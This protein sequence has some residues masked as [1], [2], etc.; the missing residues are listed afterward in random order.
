MQKALARK[1][2]WTALLHGVWHLVVVEAARP[3]AA[4]SIPLGATRM[5]S[6]HISDII[7]MLAA[8]AALC[9][10]AL[11]VVAQASAIRV[12]NDYETVNITTGTQLRTTFRIYGDDINRSALPAT[13]FATGINQSVIINGYMQHYTDTF[14]IINDTKKDVRTTFIFNDAGEY[15]ITWGVNLSKGAFGNIT[16][17]NE[18]FRVHVS[19]NQTDVEGINASEKEQG[20]YG[21][22]SN[23][24][25]VKQRLAETARQK[26]EAA[27]AAQ[28]LSNKTN[29]SANVA[30][31][32]RPPSPPPPVVVVEEVPPTV[33][34]PQREPVAQQQP[35]PTQQSQPLPPTQLPDRTAL[36]VVAIAFILVL[37][38]S[39]MQLSI[40]LRR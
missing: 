31:P 14:T 36:A 34:S 28:V 2:Q 38:P 24:D 11:C 39:I 8:V 6:T 29:V 30:V 3:V 21:S 26:E 10:V 13:F 25:I 18:S 20:R 27:R 37:I 35:Q 7:R 1:A 9:I 12:Y 23:N 40:E 33:P 15:I 4:N 16:M 17:V 32:I 22:A 19:G 5:N